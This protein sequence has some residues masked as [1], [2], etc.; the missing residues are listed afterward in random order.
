[1]GKR[2]PPKKKPPPKR[3]KYT[4]ESSEDEE[5]DSR[6][7]ATR[8]TAATVSYKEE[9][10]DNTDSED[11]LE[12]DNSAPVEPVPEDKSET[13]ERVLSRR[14]GKK[15]ITGNVTTVYAVEDNGDLNII[16]KDTP[17]ETQ[18][19][20]KWKDWSHI[21][22]TWESETS[23]KDQTVKGIKKLENF[24]KREVEIAQWR[25]HASPEDIEYHECQL[26][27]AQGLLNSY[28]MVERIIAK[29]NRPDGGKDFFVK[30]ECLPYSEATWEDSA[31]IQR[32]WPQKIREFVD[33]EESKRTPSKHC[34]ALRSR[35]KFHEA[36]E[37]P[38][39][40]KGADGNLVLRDYQLDGLNWLIHSWSKD[41]SVILADE[42]GLGKTIQVIIISLKDLFCVL[43]LILWISRRFVSCITYLIRIKCTGHFCVLCHCQL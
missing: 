30:W 11:L 37:Q 5:D 38:D 20:I 7:K 33:R 18:Y 12:V 13:I 10:E 24:K 9:S 39:Y 32:K 41:N 2:Q 3:S 31:L 1:M 27:L 34:K 29:Y 8:R 15:G 14:I 16:D 40:M 36:K 43:N 21:H 22:N 42:M 23:L 6:R 17:T 35:P 26:E 25:R 28:N 19:L 4:S